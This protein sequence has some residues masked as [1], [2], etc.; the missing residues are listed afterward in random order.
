MPSS[1][2]AIGNTVTLDE[3]FS[4]E[5]TRRRH[6]EL[7]SY[8]S[9]RSVAGAVLEDEVFVATSA[10]IFHGARLGQGAEVRALPVLQEKRDR[11]SE[12]Y[13]VLHLESTTN[14][15][16]S[17]GGR[18]SVHALAARDAGRCRNIIGKQG[19]MRPEWSFQILP[20]GQ[21]DTAT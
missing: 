19:S 4:R 21:R 16:Q 8:R 10:T 9:E 3:S 11:A 14:V 18:S 20:W 12:Q 7:L 15:S 17:A 5:S 1:R 2:N 6:R 13:H